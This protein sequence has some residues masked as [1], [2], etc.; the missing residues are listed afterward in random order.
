MGALIPEAERPGLPDGFL[1]GPWLNIEAPIERGRLTGAPSVLLRF[2]AGDL[3][4]LARLL[5]VQALSRAHGVPALGLHVPGHP[6]ERQDACLRSAILREGVT[7]PIRQ[8]PGGR[9]ARK[10]AIPSEGAALLLDPE[11]RIAAR[12]PPGRLDRLGEQLD[13]LGAGRSG[14][15][16]PGGRGLAP[17]PT[18]LLHPQGM[19]SDG[20][21]IAVADTVHHRV[22]VLA[23]DGAVEHVVGAGRPGRDDGPLERARFTNP[24]GLTFADERLVVADSGNGS[25]REID[26]ETGTTRTLVDARALDRVLGEP[27]APGP[28][29]WGVAWSDAE[30][31]E[32]VA[33]VAAPGAL[34]R[35]DPAK[36]EPTRVP[37]TERGLVQPTGI[38]GHE[39]RVFVADSAQAAVRAVGPATGQLR[40]LSDGRSGPL[41]HP[42]ALA[43]RR[44][45]RVLAIADPYAGAFLALDVRTGRVTRLEGAE[46]FQRGADPRTL[47][48]QGPDRLWTVDTDQE[49]LVLDPGPP[50][51][52]ERIELVLPWPPADER[53]PLDP[54]E[55][56]P[57]G[58][59]RL[60]LAARGGAG[61]GSNPQDPYV[62]G[63]L[64]PRRLGKTEEADGALV[65]T[66][67]GPAVA[68]GPLTVRWPLAEGPGAPTAAWR[69]PVLLRPGG[70]AELEVELS[71][72]L[73][74]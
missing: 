69:M 56:A 64:E 68:S 55:V 73:L 34:V 7:A 72:G 17:R 26:L 31:S 50:A 52:A 39:G 16:R 2:R 53:I 21:R 43:W 54:L 67:E 14:A 62:R 58:I 8:D 49:M 20:T 71:T 38:V 63:P 37:V 60:R 12:L 47:G 40:T 18:E 24:R 15:E 4:S 32:L 35:I 28:I 11:A 30:R 61:S 45:D 46:R 57:Q 3:P 6:V 36:N 1:Q 5:Q 66:L 51:Q 48:V 74:G 23:A 59:L 19:A 29:P 65:R 25:I 70:P 22:L 27:S 10:L 13:L 9:L 44:P 41:E 33:T 42:T